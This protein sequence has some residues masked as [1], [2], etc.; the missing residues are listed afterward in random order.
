MSLSLRTDRPVESNLVSTLPHPQNKNKN[1][2]KKKTPM[3]WAVVAH[4]FNPIT[5]E[6]VA[7]RFL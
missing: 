6:A 2:K 7:G 3:L 4:A 1:K 5:Q